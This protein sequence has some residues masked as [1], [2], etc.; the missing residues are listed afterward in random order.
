V[1]DRGADRWFAQRQYVGTRF[2]S[3]Y[4][5]AGSHRVARHH[6]LVLSQNLLGRLDSRPQSPSQVITRECA[7]CR[8][9]PEASLVGLVLLGFT[10]LYREGFEVV[11]FLQ[12]YH[13][14]LGGA[15]VLKGALLGIVL[16]G[17]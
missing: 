5:V 13:L 17:W 14:R 3:R 6:E 15:V 12:S 1:V 4:R 9:L 16:T 2:A 11:L 7:H 8:Y 10:S